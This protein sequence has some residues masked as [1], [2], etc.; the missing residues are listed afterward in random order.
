MEEE[1]EQEQQSPSW[2]PDT[3][4]DITQED[5]ERLE[6]PDAAPI[7]TSEVERMEPAEQAVWIEA[8]KEELGSLD[9][10]E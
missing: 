2:T 5:V 9:K 7:S 3:A 1:R 8:M 4:T 10:R 6:G